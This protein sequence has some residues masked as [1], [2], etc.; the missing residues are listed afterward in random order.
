[1]LANGGALIK[2]IPSPYVLLLWNDRSSGELLLNGV[3]ETVLSEER[4][5]S[6]YNEELFG[7]KIMKWALNVHDFYYRGTHERA[8]KEEVRR[9]FENDIYNLDSS[10]RSA[11]SVKYKLGGSRRGSGRSGSGGRV[12]PESSLT[13]DRRQRD[14]RYSERPG[15]SELVCFYGGQRLG[16]AG[17]KAKSDSTRLREAMTLKTGSGVFIHALCRP[18]PE[19]AEDYGTEDVEQTEA[20]LICHSTA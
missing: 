13:G 14:V 3:S 9:T 11:L 7:T 17:G 15:A 4:K 8:S 16:S 18:G 19:T 12:L 6:Y 10:M 20:E 1:M 5:C 2:E